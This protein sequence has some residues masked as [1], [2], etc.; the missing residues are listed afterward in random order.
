MGMSRWAEG[1]DFLSLLIWFGHLPSAPLPIRQRSFAAA[2]LLKWRRRITFGYLYR[3][4][5]LE[6][7]MI[8]RFSADFIIY[9]LG[10]ALLRLLPLH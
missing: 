8:A 2:L 9:V 7:A 5:R 10:V 1:G 4:R 6:S 3:K